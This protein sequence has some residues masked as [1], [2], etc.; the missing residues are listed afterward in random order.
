LQ[1]FYRFEVPA[2]AGVVEKRALFRV[3]LETLRDPNLTGEHKVKSLSLVV[4]P[5]LATTLEDPH[6][7]NSDV[8]TD[9]LVSVCV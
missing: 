1:D 3:F 2:L 8:V 7:K 5:V 9:E 4:I 6:T